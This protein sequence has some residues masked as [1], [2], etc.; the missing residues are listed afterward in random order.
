MPIPPPLRPPLPRLRSAVRSWLTALPAAI[1]VL[2]RLRPVPP[3]LAPFSRRTSPVPLRRPLSAVSQFLSVVNRLPSAMSR[4]PSAVSP[5]ANA[6]QAPANP[7]CPRPRPGLRLPVP[8]L[9]PAMPANTGLQ[10]PFARRRFAPQSAPPRAKSFL[11][12]TLNAREA[13]AMPGL[14]RVG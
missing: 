11:E 13:V 2:L 12:K 4:F 10:S 9:G 1:A 5:G 3:G 7:A 14:R 6:G 8:P